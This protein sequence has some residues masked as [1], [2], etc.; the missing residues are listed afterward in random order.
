[1]PVPVATKSAPAQ[2][3]AAVY[4]VL[5]RQYEGKRRVYAGIEVRNHSPKPGSTGVWEEAAKANSCGDRTQQRTKSDSNLPVHYYCSLRLPC[6]SSA[7]PSLVLTYSAS[8][9]TLA[10]PSATLAYIL[11]T[12]GCPVGRE[13][14]LKVCMHGLSASSL[15]VAKLAAA[16]AMLG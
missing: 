2:R 12:L 4:A 13:L 7:L 8:A 11:S 10:F 16:A 9:S 1:M 5:C 3:S 15:K 6:P 14:F